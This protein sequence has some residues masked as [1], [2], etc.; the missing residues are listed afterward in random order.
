M[1][2]D[3]SFKQIICCEMICDVLQICVA[4]CSSVPFS[5]KEL[6]LLW[7]PNGALIDTRTNQSESHPSIDQSNDVNQKHKHRSMYLKHTQYLSHRFNWSE[8]TIFDIVKS[9]H[10]TYVVQ[11]CEPSGWTV[12]AFQFSGIIRLTEE[13]NANCCPLIMLIEGMSLELGAFERMKQR[14]TS[15]AQKQS[16]S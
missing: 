14:E 15:E 6:W 9:Y 7:Q 2:F 4:R 16:Y 3:S 11:V 5:L 12:S 10:F 13:T 8:H 1:L